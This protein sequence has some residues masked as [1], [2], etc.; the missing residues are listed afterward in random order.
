MKKILFLFSAI[1]ITG[2]FVTSCVKDRNVGPDFSNTDP[3]LE[4]RTPISNLAGLSNFSRTVIGN[5][6]DTVKFYVNLASD[7]TLD[8]DVNVTVGVDA[9]RL[10]T[11]N[12]DSANV[13]KYT[14]LPDSDYTILKTAGTI[15]K[16]Q[17]VDS[18]QIVF[19]KDKI[20]ATSNYLLPVAITDGSGILISQNQSV[21]WFHAIGNPIAGVYDEEWKRWDATDTT[22][23]PTYDEEVGPVGFAPDSPTKVTVQSQGTGDV[24]IITFTNT[25]GVLSSFDVTLDNV[26]TITITSGPFIKADPDNGTYQVY[27]TYLNGSGLPRCILNIY[28]KQ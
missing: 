1:L 20:D 15:V 28:T 11:Y 12:A 7:Y 8:H 18:F 13:V 22:G 14:A 9:G 6:S 10:D 5:L 21:I 19:Y 25:N 26:S 16:G 4:L 2:I 24:N 23:D 27:F 17:R 3:V